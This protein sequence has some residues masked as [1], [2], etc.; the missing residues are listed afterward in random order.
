MNKRTFYKTIIEFE[1]LS[2]EP[3]GEVD[4]EQI[5]YETIEGRWSG[6]FL[7]TSEKKLNGKQA[8]RALIKQG[9]DPEFF[10][11]DEDGNNVEEF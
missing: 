11:L 10:G 9:S 4:L 6:R 3:I 5:H 7:E 1:I 2:E 8:A